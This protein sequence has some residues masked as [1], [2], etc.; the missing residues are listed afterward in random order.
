MSIEVISYS[1]NF[2]DDISYNVLYVWALMYQRAPCRFF[3][4]HPYW[5]WPCYTCMCISFQP[6]TAIHEIGHALGLFHTQSRFDRDQYVRVLLDNVIE[7]K[8]F[9]FLR[10]SSSVTTTFGLPYDYASIMHYSGTVRTCLLTNTITLCIIQRETV[11][12]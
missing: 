9:N 8:Q 4:L 1:T 12:T 6:G 2:T 10:S 5:E 11:T 3:Q 7:D